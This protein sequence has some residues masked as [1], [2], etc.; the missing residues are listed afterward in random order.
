MNKHTV[1][2]LAATLLL[3]TGAFAQ[4]K[5]EANYEEQCRRAAPK[6]TAA[7]Q[8]ATRQKCI[9]E[10]KKV[11][12]TNVPGMADQPGLSPGAAAAR[13]TP[14]EAKAAR[15]KRQAMG[16]EVAKQPKQDPKQPT[17]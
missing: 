8:A 16:A 2:A 9:D 7:E 13:A 11:A 6:G 4:T 15:E 12:K 17:Q 3:S 10:A 14:A 1:I 5:G